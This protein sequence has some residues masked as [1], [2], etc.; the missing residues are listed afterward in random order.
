MTEFDGTQVNISKSSINTNLS[1]ST[2]E[3]TVADPTAK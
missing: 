1:F 2:I 3:N